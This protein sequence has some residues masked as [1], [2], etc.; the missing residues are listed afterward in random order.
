MLPIYR[1][2][3]HLQQ[4]ALWPDS[5]PQKAWQVPGLGQFGDICQGVYAQDVA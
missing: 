2:I 3:I 5:I 1:D 4:F